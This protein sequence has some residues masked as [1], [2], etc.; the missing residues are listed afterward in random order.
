METCKPSRT[1]MESNLRLEQALETQ[2]LGKPYR[3][4]LGCLT[5][6]V[7]TSRSDLGAAVSFFSQFQCNP[8]E[9]HWRHAKRMLRYLKGTLDYGLVYKRN[10]TDR[11]IVGFTDASWAADANDRRSTSGYLL[12][13]YGSTTAWSSKKQITVALSSTEAECYALADCVCEVLW[14]RKLFAELKLLD[15]GPVEDL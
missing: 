4:L 8:S 1:P 10:E 3:E 15:S 7:V 12:Q 2:H 11:Q 9:Q 14:T 6:L 13:V 5:Y